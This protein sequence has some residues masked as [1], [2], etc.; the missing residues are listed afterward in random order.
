MNTKTMPPIHPGEVLREE[1]MEPL[2]L[3]AY[4]VAKDISV[5]APRV[6]QIVHCKRSI[7]ADT[8]L[9]LAKYFGTSPEFWLNLQNHHDLELEKDRLGGRLEGIAA[10]VGA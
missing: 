8:A 7:S 9:R 10:P 6:Y 3:T 4:R 2:N 1:F 5:P